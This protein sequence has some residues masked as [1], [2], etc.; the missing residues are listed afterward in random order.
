MIKVVFFG[1]PNVG[2]SSYPPN[3][4]G[5][6][7]QYDSEQDITST[8]ECWY[9]TTST[10]S[11]FVYILKGLKNRSKPNE[12]RTGSLLGVTI[13]IQSYGLKHD[14][15]NKVFNFLENLFINLFNDDNLDLF[16]DYDPKLFKIASFSER[17]D[18][19]DRLIERVNSMFLDQ[20]SNVMEKL[21][22]N[23]RKIQLF[24]KSTESNA[25]D[26]KGYEGEDNA[27]SFDIEAIIVE[28]DENK[29]LIKKLSKSILKFRKEVSA[30]K[31]IAVFSGVL[32][33]LLL[34]YVVSSLGSKTGNSKEFSDKETFIFS[35]K[36]EDPL[37]IRKE[38]GKNKYYL[39]KGV[40]K[41]V[42]GSNTSVIKSDNDFLIL[43]SD[44][45]I[46]SK[47]NNND[48]I[49]KESL[50]KAIKANNKKDLEQLDSLIRNVNQEI[51]KVKLIEFYSEFESDILIHV[52]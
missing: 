42:L 38:G 25:K 9:S 11:R 30:L 19:F 5:L 16:E 8:K 22:G 37:E 47:L 31:Y 13:L 3:D 34:V 46:K 51:L 18:Q 1:A 24:P 6:V 29:M 12:V 44:Y 2:F 52:N 4:V 49:T 32:S 28:L 14:S 35:T 7:A 40:I 21:D 17:S 48:D 27:R 23:I 26:V 50:A 20:F 43:L 39:K 10:S 41:K 33:I 45:I 36:K 15:L